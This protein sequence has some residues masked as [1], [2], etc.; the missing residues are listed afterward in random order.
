MK[1]ILVP[2]DFSAC[3]DKAVDFAVQSAKFLSMEVTLLH[4]FHPGNLYT[5]YMRVNKE[6]NQSQLMM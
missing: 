3:A 4:A 2:T 1:Q 5:D 6:F